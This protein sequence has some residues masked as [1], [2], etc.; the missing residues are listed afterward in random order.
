MEHF[1]VF[2]QQS[3]YVTQASKYLPWCLLTFMV[4]LGLSMFIT[5]VMIE[6]AQKHKI[7]DN[8]DGDLKNH[9]EPTPYLGGLGI[10]IAFV[11]T[12]GLLLHDFSNNQIL[13]VLLA[14]SMV[15]ILGL[16]DDFGA[17]TPFIKFLGQFLAA[18]FLYKSGVK[19][20]IAAFPEKINLI[21]T[22]LWVV[23][24]CNAFN[25]IDIM[26]GLAAGVG[27]IASLFLF[28][29][30]IFKGNSA[31]ISIVTLALSGSI[32]GF[33]RYN[34]RPAKIYMGDTGSMFIGVV[35]ASLTMMVSYGD[36]NPYSFLA[37]FFIFSVPIFDTLFVMFHRARQKISVF[38]GSPDHFAL[39]IRRWNGSTRKTVISIYIAATLSNVLGVVFIF[40]TGKTAPL[41]ILGAYLTLAFMAGYFISKLK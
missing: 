20:E 27:A 32:L 41:I 33:L 9:K 38:M 12:L 16:I 5:P 29:M 24:I 11:V 36:D 8:P 30:I 4:S 37:P 3:Q 39:K 28:L 25:I 7:V 23:G 21:L 40:S 13:G 35:L 14:G 19:I 34:Y 31:L 18:F 26:D 10:Y 6:A 1:F 22:C 15:L 2:A 17:L